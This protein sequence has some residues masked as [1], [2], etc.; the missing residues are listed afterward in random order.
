MIVYFGI[1]ALQVLCVVDVIRRGRNSIWIMAL[2]FLPVAS[3]LAYFIV[4]IL[5]SLQH[6]RH[7]R[8]ARQTVIE[9]LDPERELRSA[10]QGLDI[11]DTMANRLRVADVLTA[12]GRHSEALPLYQRGAGPRPDFRTGE[13]LARSLFLND[14]PDEALSVIDALP[15]VTAQSEVDRA[16]LLRARIFEDLKRSDEALQLYAD[17]V[18]RVPGD[19]ARC[20]YAALLITVGRKP[21]ARRVLEDV[22]HRMKYIDRNTR[23]AQG[24][25]Y[26]WAMREL[27]TLRT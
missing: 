19:E 6:N 26:E 17:V 21:E 20:R 22:E 7:V 13:K 10:Q 18:D 15:K 12:L 24:P 8:V 4:E 3:A 2:I 23:V 5:P 11:A 27:T 16:T 14:R 1:L 9:K 25:M